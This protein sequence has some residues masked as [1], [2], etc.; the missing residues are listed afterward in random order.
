MGGG[1]GG[2]SSD[3][4]AMLLALA[5]LC[6]RNC[7]RWT[8]LQSLAAALGSDVP[9][10]LHRRRGARAR[11][12]RGTLPACRSRGRMPVLILAPPIHVSTPE[13]YKA[14]EPAG[15]DKRPDCHLN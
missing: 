11:P 14:L 13:A 5:G 9:F 4:A 15:F 10:F 1:L 7:R 12:R 3:A 6:G 8:L 2:G